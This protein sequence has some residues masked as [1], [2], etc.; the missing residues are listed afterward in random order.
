MRRARSSSPRRRTARRAWH[1]AGTACRA[2]WWCGPPGRRAR[3]GPR[4]PRCPGC[5]SLL[6]LSEQFTCHV[7]D[8]FDRAVT[9]Q[10]H[11]G[12][13]ACPAGL[14]ERA[15]RGAVVTVEVLAEDQVVV[16][17]RI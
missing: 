15:D 17:G 8:G 1:R 2:G 7:A 4:R 5:W 12:D 14:M 3:P 13:Q 6:R 9:A 10:D 11:V 16:P